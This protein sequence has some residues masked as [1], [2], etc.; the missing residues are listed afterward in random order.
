MVCVITAQLIFLQKQ[1]RLAR[2]GEAPGSLKKGDRLLSVYL[3]TAAVT[4]LLYSSLVFFLQN[5]PNTVK[6]SLVL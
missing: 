6:D 3:F 2:R 1:G 5:L 4:S